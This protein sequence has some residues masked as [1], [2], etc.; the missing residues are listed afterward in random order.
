MVF[1]IPLIENQIIITHF[2]AAQLGS[3]AVGG[4]PKEMI[5]DR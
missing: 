4:R 2:E 5:I 1:Q 3:K